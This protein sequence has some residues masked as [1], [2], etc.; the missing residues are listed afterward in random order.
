M[1]GI[2]AIVAP[3]A[4]ST[5]DVW[6]MLASIR[7]RGPDGFGL[8]AFGPDGPS[9]QRSADDSPARADVVL[10]H[11]RLAILDLS[12]AGFQPM[13]GED[14]TVWVS[15]NGELYNHRELR[16]ELEA[17]GHRFRSRCDVEVLVHGYEEWGEQVV[18]RIE[19][20]FAFALHDVERR[21]TLLARDRLGV[22]PL[23]YARR[24]DGA[25]VAG[26]EIKALLAA[27]VE[28]RL[29]PLGL[30]HFLSWLWVP[31]PDT[32]FDGVKK[33]E[34][35]C[36]LRIEEDGSMA[37]GRYWDFA[38][39]H[40]A[41]PRPQPGEL[42]EAVAAA[43]GRQLQSDVP[44]GAFFSGGIDSTAIVEL[45]RRE[46]APELPTCLTVGFSRRDLRTEAVV[47]DLAY[48]RRYAGRTAVDYRELELDPGLTDALPAVVWHLDEPIADPAALSSY[49]ICEAAAGDLTVLLSGM[50]GDELF[51]GYPRYVATALA[52]AARRIPPPL[53]AAMQAA[54]AAIPARGPGAVAKLRTRAQKLLATADR[55]F[56][57]DYL[58]LLTSFD[59]DGRRALYADDVAAATAGADA[60]DVHRAH[61]AAAGGRHW[62]DQAMHLDLKTFLASHNLVYVDK[63]SMAHSIEVRVPLLD[64]LVVDVVRRIPP[65]DRVDGRRTKLL[66]KEAMRGIVPDDIVD[67]RKAG[68]GAPLRAWLAGE[69]RPLVDD[70]LSPAAVKRRGLFRPEAVT[71][72]VADFR[73]GRRD[74]AYQ[75]WQLLTLELWHE[76]FLDSGSR[77][78]PAAL[79]AA[80]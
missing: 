68:F 28:A 36:L 49:R 39:D 65:Q 40:E 37:L 72:V 50:G 70:L 33:L 8:V 18:E 59:T 17:R 5:A 10:G 43:V 54:A 25:L 69:L 31:D 67:R 11:A 58:G 20:M 15:C 63:T 16:R 26:S 14:S 73:S 44:L 62:L 48:A 57:D 45:M 61:L 78:R 27:G 38:W 51:G 23:Y 64:E 47:D 60:E 12:E 34:P 2:A 56:P 41:G 75:L 1:C 29:D 13:A 35:G 55:T 79:A 42:R 3:S 9:V 30:D 71:A 7:H 21:V 53:R 76:A 46:I 19:G 6:A 80:R 32:A 74:T 22:K 66:F 77:A 4:V 52:G 24:P